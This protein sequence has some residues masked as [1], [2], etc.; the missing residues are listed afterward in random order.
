MSLALISKDSLRLSFL[1]N[2]KRSDTPIVPMEAKMMGRIVDQDQL[3]NII[4]VTIIVK[5][6]YM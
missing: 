6:L 2:A 5:T 1:A 4:R 3:S